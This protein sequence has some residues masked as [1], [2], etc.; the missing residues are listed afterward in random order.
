[1][2]FREFLDFVNEERALS[3]RLYRTVGGV[4]AASQQNSKLPGAKIAATSAS[5]GKSGT[6][7]PQ[8]ESCPQCS[9]S[10]R[11]AS[12]DAFKKAS[13]EEKRKICFGARICYK[14]LEPGHVAK[15]CKTDAR[16]ETCLR[17]HLTMMHEVNAPPGAQNGAASTT[18]TTTA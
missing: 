7:P 5:S 17:Q 14:C 6:T 16:C 9:A 1:M 11:L 12:C 13:T 18:P 8:T 4:G 10:H 3:D 2:S 15:F